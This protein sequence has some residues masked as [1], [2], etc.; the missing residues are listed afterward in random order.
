[1]PGEN[2]H[3]CLGFSPPCFVTWLTYDCLSLSAP[4]PEA[5]CSINEGPTEQDYLKVDRSIISPRNVRFLLAR[6]ARSIK[7]YYPLPIPEIAPDEE[8]VLKRLPDLQR[9]KILMACATAA[10]KESFS[11]PDWRVVAKVCREWANELMIPIVS[12]RDGEALS[13]VIQLLIFEL[14]DPAKGIIWELLDLAIRTCLQLGWHRGT[15]AVGSPQ[16]DLL[17]SNDVQ[18]VVGTSSNRATLISVL[19]SI[20]G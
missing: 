6:Y 19:T 9:F 13:A 10:A 18:D 1:M 3:I 12:A 4:L 17:K 11:N 15:P 16:L 5:H 2:H 20:E 8:H 7:P 14:V